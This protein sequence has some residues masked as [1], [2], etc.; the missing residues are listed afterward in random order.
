MNL[1]ALIATKS[2]N[3]TSSI[4]LTFCALLISAVILVIFEKRRRKLIL[5]Q[6]SEVERIQRLK[7]IDYTE[8][9]KLIVAMNCLPEIIEEYPM[10]DVHLRIAAM[11]SKFYALF[12]LAN[13]ATALIFTLVF[14]KNILNINENFDGQI[15][16]QE[17]QT[18]PYAFLLISVA[19]F[20]IAILA[21]CEFLAGRK[22]SHG[23][24]R[25]RNFLIFSWIF[26]PLILSF[27]FIASN[28]YIKYLVIVPIALYI[29]WTLILRNNSTA[30]ISFTGKNNTKIAKILVS[31]TV[32]IL[33][34]SS[35]LSF[36]GFFIKLNYDSMFSTTNCK[37]EANEGVSTSSNGFGYKINSVRF[38]IVEKNDKE[39]I[40]VIN[41]LQSSLQK[42][43]PQIKFVIHDD[44][45]D[46]NKLFNS[47]NEAVL[48]VG[49]LA[50]YRHDFLKR[51]QKNYENAVLN[52]QQRNSFRSILKPFKMSKNKEVANLFA[53]LDN[54]NQQTLWRYTSKK[55]HF[56]IYR[57]F[58][59]CRSQQYRHKLHLRYNNMCELNMKYAYDG[60]EEKIYQKMYDFSKKNL[61]KILNKNKEDCNN[62]IEIPE[63]LCQKVL[64]KDSI[65]NHL[66][67]LY[68]MK[69][70]Q[71]LGSFYNCSDLERL[72]YKSPISKDKGILQIVKDYRNE[73]KKQ[74]WKSDGMHEGNFYKKDMHIRLVFPN[75]YDDHDSKK[76]KVKNYSLDYLLVDI[77]KYRSQDFSKDNTTK[78]F[79]TNSRLFNIIAINKYFSA[80]EIVKYYQQTLNCKIELSFDELKRMYKSCRQSK[81]ISHKVKEKLL[82]RIEKRICQNAQKVKESITNNNDEQSALDAKNIIEFCSKPSEVNTE[83]M[84]RIFKIF[85]D[86]HIIINE[87]KF[88]IV[89]PFKDKDKLI[90]T[91]NLKLKDLL[92]SPKLITI[93]NSYVT[94]S[95]P[96]NA[97]V[98]SKIND[99]GKQVVI[100]NTPEWG[101]TNE[102]P[103]TMQKS[104]NTKKIVFS[105]MCSYY[106]NW[107]QVNGC[108]SSTIDYIAEYF[109]DSKLYDRYFDKY[110]YIKLIF[111]DDNLKDCE[112]V[113]YYPEKFKKQDI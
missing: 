75:S 107:K 15:T 44:K 95:M 85:K 42:K 23:S 74:G 10:P 48:A 81:K 57:L 111:T 29:L 30:K 32:V 24:I 46:N 63:Y 20:I 43:F 21:V 84:N 26:N 106:K 19:C 25:A 7:D 8:K 76:I 99:Q 96:I 4:F 66:K 11:L 65:K 53:E 41:K 64:A 54:Y 17:H 27:G 61:T 16:F 93:Y 6:S 88:S 3:Y 73:L 92:K 97:L 34:I 100:F 72:V 47:T 79:D 28:L 83:F 50:Y 108:G 82:K 91:V 37:F 36:H 71:L 31:S 55:K 98:Y 69:K 58:Q 110:F 67:K 45:L 35:F 78:L 38:L 52:S 40:N 62:L 39:L 68:F 77:S 51:E 49:N 60:T 70:A 105:R 12:K 56:Y 113:V 104:I 101:G 14:A 89:N 2:F 109:D 22:V 112:L 33:L 90:K 80:D 94:D 87:E 86:Y 102:L 59:R 9:R 103:K 5:K 13:I 18:V 1:F